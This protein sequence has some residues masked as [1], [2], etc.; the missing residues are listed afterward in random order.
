MQHNNVDIHMLNKWYNLLCVDTAIQ[1]IVH[2]RH[3]LVTSPALCLSF[4]PIKQAINGQSAPASLAQLVA[5]RSHN[6]NP[7][8]ANATCEKSG[9]RE[10]DPHREQ[11]SFL[12]SVR[13]PC[14][15]L[16]L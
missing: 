16:P 14:S 4:V 3:K 12:T 11:Q 10:F 13:S 1:H 8:L 15:P 6:T 7:S 9:G 5:R 2:T